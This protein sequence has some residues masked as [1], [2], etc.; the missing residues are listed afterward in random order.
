MKRFRFNLE[1]LLEL[2]A[3]DEKKWEIKLGQIVSKCNSMERRIRDYK[4][5]KTKTFFKYNLTDSGMDTLQISEMY[6]QKLNYEIR[7]ANL[8]LDTYKSEKQK[9]QTKYIEASNKR[10]VLDK[11]KDKEALTYYKE[12]A[13]EEIKEIDDISIGIALR[14]RI[15]KVQSA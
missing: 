1:K 11:L 10:K 8:K 2:R 12:Q 13:L 3:Y 7:Q 9:V 5:E 6:L 15:N 14:K 4:S